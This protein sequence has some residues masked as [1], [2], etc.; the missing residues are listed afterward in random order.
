MIY[1]TKSNTNN[2]N[3]TWGHPFN[4]TTLSDRIK[5]YHDFIYS[6]PIIFILQWN[7]LPATVVSCN[8]LESF[9]KNRNCSYF[10][11]DNL[12]LIKI[13][14]AYTLIQKYNAKC[15]KTKPAIWA[16]LLKE[17]VLRYH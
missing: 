9:K 13:H 12:F 11:T 1:R 10:L 2:T 8:N 16:Y 14:Y 15:C 17:P 3:Q 5:T 6:F 7:N 4:S